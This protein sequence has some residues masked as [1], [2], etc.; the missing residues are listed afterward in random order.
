[1]MSVS[2]RIGAGFLA[3]LLVFCLIPLSGEAAEKITTT[4]TGYISATDVN[5]VKDGKYIANWGARG[6]DCVF[7]SSYAEDFYTGSN[8]FEVLSTLTG[9]S[10]QTNAPYSALYKQLQK[11]LTSKHTFFTYYDDPKNVRDFYQ[12]TDCVSCDISQVALLY[13]GGLVTSAWNSGNIWNQ[14]HVWPKSKL[15]TR[16]QIGDIMHLRPANP[17]ENTARSNTAY[18][19]GSGYYDPGVSVR[20]DC[21]RMVLYMYV[22]WGVTSTMWGKS[23]VIENLN[24]L[25]QWMS[26]DPVDTWEMGRNDAV[27]SVTGTRNAF[28]DYPEF[29]WLL[30]GQDVPEGITTPSGNDGVK[31]NPGEYGDSGNSDYAQV[32]SLKDG[33]KVVIVNPASNM[34][35]STSKI[36]TYYNAGV[37]VS[38]GFG[39]ISDKE[40]FTAKKNSDGSWSFTSGDGKK[41]AL[42]AEYSSLNETG[43]NDKW[44]LSSAGANQ[45]Y[46][47]N[48]GRNLYL[49]W[50]ASRGNWSAYK[51]DSLNADYILAFYTKTSTDS[52][53]NNSGSTNT[54]TPPETQPPETQPPVTQP[55]ETQP[56][57]TQPVETQQPVDTTTPSASNPGASEDTQASTPAAQP[58]QSTSLPTASENP[59]DSVSEKEEPSPSVG[60][61]VA[62]IAVLLLAGIV[63]VIVLKKKQDK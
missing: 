62:I 45:F 30:F 46:L 60:A 32:S 41:L 29:A 37:D 56:P 7:L 31:A 10:N 20:G 12:Y 4:P 42:A 18:G 53:N 22:R 36:A 26:E 21:A 15:S 33:D 63:V 59:D 6:E 49:E 19:M 34:A 47:L 16:E 25:L 24:V 11:L 55:P 27:Q 51:P 48:T 14:E 28:V 44:T 50:Y 35:L 3:F 58:S 52:S 39:N 1:M 57:V 8:T 43:V 61:V 38:F 54:T 13:R 2:K 23:G 17:S 9:G 40:I 5:Y